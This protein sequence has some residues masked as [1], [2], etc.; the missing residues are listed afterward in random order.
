MTT[1]LAPEIARLKKE[2]NAVL[3]AH[4]Y[5]PGEVQDVADFVGDSLGLSVEASRVK[6][7]MIVF[8]GVRFMAE[9]AAV[10]NP[11]RRVVL[12]VPHA[13]CPMADMITAQELAAFKREHPGRVVLCYVNSTADVKAQSDVCV[14]SSNAVAIARLV[15]PDKGILFVPDKHLGDFVMQQTGRDVVCW[16][17]FCP[18]HACITPA[19]IEQARRAH[20]DAVVMIHPEAPRESRALADTVLST[21]GMCAYAKEHAAREFIVATEIGILHTLRKQ[22]RE[23]RFYPVSPSITCPD[24]RKGSLVAVRRALDGTGGE[25]I[26]VPEETARQ[27]ELAI[28]RMIE[29]GPRG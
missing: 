25:V 19:M 17:G 5:Q 7:D 13:G 9:T 28:R 23:K 20:P 2:K 6:A 12:A 15:E 22:N 26:R 8:C 29:A 3:L 11:S 24:M 4:T 14:T 10:I 18:T 27:A 16:N 1:D 21:G